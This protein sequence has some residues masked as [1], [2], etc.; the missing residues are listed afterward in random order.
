MSPRWSRSD[1]AVT[2]IGV[3]IAVAV[4]FP[5]YAPANRVEPLVLGLP[6]SMFWTVLWIALGAVALLL[7]YLRD[8]REPDEPTGE[9]GS[10]EKGEG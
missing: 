4:T 8:Q 5:G 7:V 3:V 10:G 2:V 9:G 1:T 6:F